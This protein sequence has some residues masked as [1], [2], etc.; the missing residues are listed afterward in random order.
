MWLRMVNKI[1]RQLLICQHSTKV[2]KPQDCPYVREAS[3]WVLG[4][5][6]TL[7]CV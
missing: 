5:K 3:M 6:F 7:T 4:A 2:S 1:G